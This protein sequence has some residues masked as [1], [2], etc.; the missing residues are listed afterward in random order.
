VDGKPLLEAA[1][2][3]V[4]FALEM[5]KAVKINRRFKVADMMYD[6]KLEF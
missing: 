5:G 3:E 2:G 1:S 6:G 4:R